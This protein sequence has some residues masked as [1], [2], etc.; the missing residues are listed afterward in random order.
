MISM[1]AFAGGSGGGGVLMNSMDMNNPEIIFHMGQTEDT[2]SFA[3][4]HLVGNEWSVERFVMPT[5]DLQQ[6]QGVAEALLKSKDSKTW[7]KIK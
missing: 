5:A 1:K 7:V 2:V 3:Y 6:D 4:G